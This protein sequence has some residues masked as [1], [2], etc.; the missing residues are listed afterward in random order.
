M[1]WPALKLLFTSG[2]PEMKLDGNDEA[3]EMRL[4]IKPYR[5]DDL[6]RTVREVL[7]ANIG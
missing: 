3:T 2:F 5:K 4:L 6:A 1:R 7:D